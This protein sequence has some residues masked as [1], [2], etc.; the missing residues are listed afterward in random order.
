MPC[1]PSFDSSTGDSDMDRRSQSARMMDGRPV[2]CY[3][4]CLLAAAQARMRMFTRAARCACAVYS[5]AQEDGLGISGRRISLAAAAT[6]T[7][8]AAGC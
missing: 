4:Y 3:N 2:L 7:R 5:Y 1:Q 8:L 6:T